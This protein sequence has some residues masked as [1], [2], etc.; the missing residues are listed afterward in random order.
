MITPTGDDYSTMS[1]TPDRG[2]RESERTMLGGRRDGRRTMRLPAA[3]LNAL[4]LR[5]IYGAEILDSAPEIYRSLADEDWGFTRYTDDERDHAQSHRSWAQLYPFQREA[6]EYLTC[7][8]HAAT[9]LALSPGLGKSAVSVVGADLIHAERILVLAPVTL[10]LNWEREFRQWSDDPDGREYHRATARSRAPGATGVTIANH[11]VIQEVVLRDE[12]GDVRQ[13]D[14]V[15]NARRVKQWRE[16]GPQVTGKN[17]RP[18]WARERVTRVRRDYRDADWDLIIVDESILLKNRR[19]LKTDVLESLVKASPDAHVWMLSGSPIAK[20]RDDLFRQLQIMAPHVFTSYW[21]FTEF[22]CVVERGQ[23]GWSVIGDRA[24][25]DLHHY[26]R[27]FVFVRSQDEVLEELPDYIY[28]NITVEPT[29]KQRKALDSMRED[30]I[31]ELEDA[32]DDQPIVASNWL[33]RLTRLQQ[34]TSN[35]RTLPAET[36]RQ[37]PTSSAKENLLVELIEQR[38]VEPPLL[39]WTWYIET[40]ASVTDRLTKR[41]PELRVG[42][43]T[44]AMSGDVKTGTIE[45]YRAGELDVLV[46]QMGVGK[47][48][49]TFTNTRTVYYH[50]RSFDSDAWVQSLRRVRRIGLEHRPVLIVPRVSDSADALVDANLDGKLPSIAELTNSDVRSLLAR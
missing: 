26:L 41:F 15:T 49:H 40:T 32:P 37:R 14:W 27:D 29:T 9:L 36:G 11:E 3:S 6:V 20:Y 12:D 4:R 38:E 7:S 19:A 5:D 16:S 1:V 18:T 10:T 28:R 46:L 24:D 8:P 39:V 13:P 47:F 17:G 50:D 43:S 21:R 30:W 33:A 48:G 44:G 34:A 2:L 42:M 35:L 22:F 25:V 31:I 23:W 45:A